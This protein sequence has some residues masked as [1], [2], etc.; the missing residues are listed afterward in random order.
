VR[1]DGRV[2]QRSSNRW[3]LEFWY[4]GNCYREPAMLPDRSGVMHPAKTEA[5]ALKRLQ[6][7]RREIMGGHFLGPREERVTVEELC[8]DLIVH[9]RTKGA[10]SLASFESHLKPVRRAFS[11]TR[12]VDL[13]TD[14]IEAFIQ[15]QLEAGA[16]PATVNRR[17]GALRQALHL[18]TKARKLS[19]VPFVPQ[20]TEDNARSGFVEP[21]TFE[22]IAA[23]LPDVVADIARFAYHS[24][25]RRG[26]VVPL[27]WDSID[28][29][30][31]EAR[32]RTTKNKRPRTL[33]LA[34]VL[35]DVIERRWQAREYL[36]TDG[37]T[38]LSEYVFHAGDGRPPVD[39]KRS[40]RT[41]CRQA[42]TPGTLFHDLRRSGVRNL[43]RG[44]TPQSVAMSISGHRTVSTFLRYD[45]ASELDKI[46][47][48]ER[49]QAHV[50]AL[51]TAPLKV[52]SMARGTK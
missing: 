44:G 39:F 5:E 35:W 21:A 43:I 32:L 33:P 36:R 19:R 18:A 31:R 2:Y 46:A 23:H 1:G 8:D 40:W 7:R 26:E 16:K 49:T 24:A 34:G 25:W 48:L 47:A 38:A 17:T 15:A 42:G 41:A 29:T 11:L 50:A 28:R 3:W 27:R 14:K 13:T 4:K 12:A 52:A 45:I 30:N 20:L 51:A 9:L 10:R 6:A 37:P 22:L